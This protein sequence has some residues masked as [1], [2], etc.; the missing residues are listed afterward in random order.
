MVKTVGFL[1]QE[2][3]EWEKGRELKKKGPD[4]LGSD[5]VW[6]RLTRAKLGNVESNPNRRPVSFTDDHGTFSSLEIRKPFKYL[7]GPEV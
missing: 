6:T 1:K 2:T 4:K 3:G 7:D 5:S